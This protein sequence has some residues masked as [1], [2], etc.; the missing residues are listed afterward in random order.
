MKYV[1]W[2]LL[3][4]TCLLSA[5]DNATPNTPEDQEVQPVNVSIRVENR[6]NDA[7]F[8]LGQSYISPEGYSI[9]PEVFKFYLSNIALKRTD[10]SL[11]TLRETALINAENAT[12]PFSS[13]V[14]GGQYDSLVIHIGIPPERNTGVDPATYANNNPLSVQQA[15]NMFW[16]WNS[17]Y[18]FL[19]Y[20]GKADLD[21]DGLLLDPF[22]LHSGDDLMFTRLAFSL[23]NANWP[24]GSTQNINLVIR[25]EKILSN[26]DDP[27]D[28]S[29]DN[30]THTS[31]NV[32]LAK[33]AMSNFA[34]AFDVFQ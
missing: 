32:A 5:C 1:F 31:G 27:I 28:I 8:V 11:V 13:S 23:G 6:Y 33:R 26:P 30:I 20:D 24:A 25:M 9:R 3:L 15:G 16:N 22:A 7:P 12:A 4:I 19:M 2:I 17:G 29:V 10:G 14:I 34:T 21:S 18:I